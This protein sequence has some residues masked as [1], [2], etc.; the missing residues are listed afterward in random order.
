MASSLFALGAAMAKELR[1]GGCR[2]V[3]VEAETGTLFLQPAAR[4]VGRIPVSG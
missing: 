1:L 4:P 2:N 3:V